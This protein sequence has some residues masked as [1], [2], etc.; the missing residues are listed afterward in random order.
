MDI[1]TTLDIEA[2]G[3]SPDSY[4]IEIGIALPDRTTWC[5]L[6]KPTANWKHWSKEAQDFHGITREDLHNSGRDIQT[7]TKTLN[8]LLHNKT[9]YTDCWVL[10]DLWIRTL[11]TQARIR[12]TFRLRD[13]M[14]ILKEDHFVSWEPTKK[15]IAQELDLQRHRASNDAKIL[16][17]TFNRVTMQHTPPQHHS[18]P[19]WK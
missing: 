5:S 19:L 15:R 7:V 17:E 3:L 8:Q 14:Y 12:P 2:S 1:I 18:H 9:V 16:Q 6:I 10:D 11:F 4:P 13:I